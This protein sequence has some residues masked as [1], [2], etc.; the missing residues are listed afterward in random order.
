MQVQAA[1]QKEAPAWE[2]M[3]YNDL[4]AA[5]KEKGIK[6]YHKMKKQELV[7]ALKG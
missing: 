7:E 4:K 2:E 3:A 6:G 5:A 1:E